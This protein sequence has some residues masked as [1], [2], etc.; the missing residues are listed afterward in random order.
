M[1]KSAVWV[2]FH[3]RLAAI[4]FLVGLIAGW[5]SLGYDW[6]WDDLHLIRRYSSQELLATLS[7]PWDPDAIETSGLRPGTTLFNHVRAAAFGER[8]VLHRLSLLALFAVYLAL[9]G[10]LA[11]KLGAPESVALIAGVLAVAAKNNYYH[12]IWISD[13]VH[14]LQALFLVI[15]THVML[16]YLAGGPPWTAVAA[17]AFAALA[18]ATREDSLAI[19][20]VMILVAIYFV[21]RVSDGSST[22]RIRIPPRLRTFA[23]G[24]MGVGAGFW[25]WRR[26]VIPGAAQFSPDAD[27]LTGVLETIGWTVGLA[28]QQPILVRTAFMAVGVAAVAALMLLDPADRRRASLWLLAALGTTMIGSVEARMNLLIFPISFYVLFL[29]SVAVALTRHRVLFRVA[30]GMLVV[31]MSVLSLRASRLEQLSLHP[32]SADQIHRDWEFIYG[33]RRAATIPAVRRQQ[34]EAKLLR[35]GVTA[36]DFDFDRWEDD[37]RQNGRRT[38]SRAGLFLANRR[39]LEP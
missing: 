16:R 36:P 31:A 35:L 2:R 3:G 34:L 37:V 21:N 7:G 14:V 30:A 5:E 15:A 12:Y 19:F 13:G 17:L 20:P 18:L 23:L 26:I 8:V 28:G 38:P 24:L 4:F 27:A 25:M 11:V 32:L 1:R 33:P 6:N 22:N 39:F 10:A 9:L 29:A